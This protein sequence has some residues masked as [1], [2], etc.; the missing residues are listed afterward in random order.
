[1]KALKNNLGSI[2][3]V[4]RQGGTKVNQYDYGKIS[5]FCMKIFIYMNMKTEIILNSNMRQKRTIADNLF[6][7]IGFSKILPLYWMKKKLRT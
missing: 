1:M 6:A 3:F 2:V 4:M 5:S 7:K